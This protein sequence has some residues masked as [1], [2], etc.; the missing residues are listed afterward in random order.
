M[1]S[2]QQQQKMMRSA[3]EK[4]I[5]PIH[6]KKKLIRIVPG[7]AQIDNLLDKYLKSVVLNVLKK[8]E[9]SRRMMYEQMENITKKV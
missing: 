5:C 1:S 3:K 8:L 2:F 6:R 7:R 4:K 9:K